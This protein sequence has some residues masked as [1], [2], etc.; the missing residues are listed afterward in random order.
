MKVGLVQGSQPGLPNLRDT[1]GALAS[2]RKM[3]EIRQALTEAHPDSVKDQIG[4]AGS[5]RFL[6]DLQAAYLGDV[7]GGFENCMKGVA[8]MEELHRAR[9]GDQEVAVELALD[10]DK[11]GDIEG[12]GNGSSAN[13]ADPHAGL[14]HHNK[15]L[16][17]VLDVEKQKG[18]G[19][20]LQRWIGIIH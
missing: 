15:E 18:T 1:A 14:D 13:L 5:Y 7:Q 9:P 11:L 3:I 12:G 2:F 6:S 17:L 8:V 10:Y 16:A 4:L 19:A 20:R